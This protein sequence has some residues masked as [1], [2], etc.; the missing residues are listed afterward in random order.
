VIAFVIMNTYEPD[1]ILSPV[2]P[3]SILPGGIQ[4]VNFIP[5][6]GAALGGLASGAASLAGGAV[7]ALGTAGGFLAETAIGAGG[8]VLGGIG[9]IGG[10]IIDTAG[11]IVSGAGE[12]LFGG[13]TAEPGLTIGEQMA[14]EAQPGYYGVTEAGGGLFDFLSADTLT[15]VASAGLGLWQS[16]EQRKL[17]E[18]AIEAQRRPGYTIGAP[19]T[20]ALAPTTSV[21]I[22]AAAA[23]QK[24]LDSKMITYAIIALALYLVLKGKK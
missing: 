13:G 16:A 6:V 4:R 9:Q 11:G 15:N 12:V 7:S 23:A 22:P 10:G 24:Q 1:I 18:K 8:A 20:T 19:G 21:A 3:N 2:L 17:A 5:F 14:L